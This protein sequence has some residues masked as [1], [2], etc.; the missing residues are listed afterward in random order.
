MLWL[1]KG[2]GPISYPHKVMS[3]KIWNTILSCRNNCGESLTTFRQSL[4]PGGFQVELLVFR[5]QIHTKP[6]SG[7]D[8]NIWTVLAILP[9]NKDYINN[10][11]NKIQSLYE[12]YFFLIFLVCVRLSARSMM[13]FAGEQTKD[14]YDRLVSERER[15]KGHHY[16]VKQSLLSELS[17]LWD[18]HFPPINYLDNYL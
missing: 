8:L 13:Y 5:I 7:W 2:Y 18:Q 11:L 3:R 1:Q 12:V 10:C 17:E 16:A 14:F 9:W 4:P 15:R 6:N